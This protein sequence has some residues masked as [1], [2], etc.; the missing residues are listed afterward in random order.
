MEQGFDVVNLSLSTTSPGLEAQLRALA[1]RAYFRRCVLVVSAH[2]MPVLSYPWTF[3]SVISVASHNEPDSLL[4][5]YNSAPPVDF[6]ARG[7]KVTVPWI[8]GGEKVSTGNSFAAPHV[9]GMCARILS[10]H[11]WLTPFQIKSVLYLTSRNV[12]DGHQSSPTAPSG[13]ES[14]DVPVG[15]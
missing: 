3:S 9:T 8:S 12:L 1:D 13:E 2:N 11:R 7:V 5:Y 4:H 10:K 15:R 14:G 6:Y